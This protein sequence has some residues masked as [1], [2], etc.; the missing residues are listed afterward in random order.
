MTVSTYIDT[1]TG[2]TVT[3]VPSHMDGHKY[4]KHMGIPEHWE[5]VKKGFRVRAK[6]RSVK[7][8]NRLAF[9]RKMVK[10]VRKE[11]KLSQIQYEHAVFDKNKFHNLPIGEKQLCYCCVKNNAQLR[12]HVISLANGGRSKENNIV[13]LCK[14][15]HTLIHPHLRGPRIM[16]K[17][18]GA[19]ASRHS[20]FPKINGP[21]VVSPKGVIVSNA[22]QRV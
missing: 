22:A 19:V 3:H 12:H 10:V 21:V 16:R 17:L 8:A 7:V 11:L 13:P 20:V 6:F 1:A 4:R 14:G 9:L 5:G 2:A 18:E 15:C